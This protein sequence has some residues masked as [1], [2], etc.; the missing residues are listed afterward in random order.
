MTGWWRAFLDALAG[1]AA[2]DDPDQC[3]DPLPP[4]NLG[5]PS[6]GWCVRRPGHGV[7]H[8]DR[9]G[10]EWTRTAAPMDAA[11]PPRCLTCDYPGGEPE[12]VRCPDCGH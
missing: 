11:A 12:P 3:G 2:A 6:T 7:P 8:R 10:A 4:L 9:D 5:G 1:R